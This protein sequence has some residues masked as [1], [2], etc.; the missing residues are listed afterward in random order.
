MAN[1]KIVPKEHQDIIID[2]YVNKQYGIQKVIK[3]LKK[4]G[5]SYGERVIKRILQENNVH[6]RNFNE[7]KVGRYKMEVPKQLQQEIIE[8]YQRGYGLEKIVEILNTSFSFDKVKS[9]LIENG[10][11]IRNLQEASQVKVIPDLR[12]YSIN[13][14]YNF[15]SHN[16]AWILGMFASDGYLPITKGAKNRM[17]LT[18]QR[19]DEDCLSLIKEELQYTGPINQYNSTLGYPNSSLAFTSY[20]IRKEFESFGIVNAKT[21]KLKHLPQNIKDEYILDFIRGYFDGDGSVYEKRG[22]VA[23]SFT[24]A[25]K[26]FLENIKKVLFQKLKLGGGSISLNHNAY[27]LKYG[28]EDTLKMCSFF[29][30]NNY[31]SLPRKKKKFNALR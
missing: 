1:K 13:D 6:I 26:T 4:I 3:E 30:D 18:L 5:L 10:I 16:G 15:Q 20:K 28:K 24:C 31:L 11:H 27:F 22:S 14:N 19:R 21:F 29:Y 25:N 9:I 2:F 7:A 23:S 17:I 8:L 12:K